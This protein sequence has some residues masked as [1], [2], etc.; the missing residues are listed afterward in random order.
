[1]GR[2]KNKKT[3]EKIIL[4]IIVAIFLAV[5][6]NF[7]IGI[8]EYSTGISRQNEISYETSFDLESIPEYKNEP[9]VVLNNNEPEFEKG[10]YTT[11]VFEEYS[12]L[13]YLGRCGV[14]FANM[15]RETMPTEERESLEYEPTGWKQKKYNGEYLYNRCHLIGH[16]LTAE[17]D[18]E[19]NLI[20][21]TRYMNVEGMLYFENQVANYIKNQGK[22]ED[23]HV[24]YRVTPIF[25]GENLLASGVQI[26]AKSVEDNGK[27][28]CFNVYVYNVQPGVVIDYSTG[29]S[30]LTQ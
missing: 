27:S 5:A 7:G 12:D 15:C 11:E 8:P 19:K 26:E 3:L 9:Y 14:A 4:G 30:K 13:D 6:S 21:G 1:M 20:T 18:N 17:N 23:N 25:E 29:E 2:R 22:N 24:L 28:I 10:D 16:Q